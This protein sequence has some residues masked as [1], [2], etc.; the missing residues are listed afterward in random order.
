MGDLQV[1][2]IHLLLHMDVHIYQPGF[3]YNNKV[4]HG[5]RRLRVFSILVP[6][7]NI[8]THTSNTGSTFICLWMQYERITVLIIVLLEVSPPYTR[9]IHIPVWQFTHC[10]S[11]LPMEYFPL[12]KLQFGPSM[13]T[14]VHLS[15]TNSVLVL[16]T[17]LNQHSQP[18]EILVD[19]PDVP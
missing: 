8:S 19:L 5:L 14:L 18:E 4:N 9:N 1:A 3:D 7:V 13:D 15:T 16:H 12:L 11:L 17:P 2:N 10:G 6:Q